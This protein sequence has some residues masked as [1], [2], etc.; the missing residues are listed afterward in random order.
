MLVPEPFAVVTVILLVTAPEG[1]VAVIWL[2]EF[3]VKAALVPRN[4][5][6]V[7]PV[8]DLPVIVTV[9]PAGPAG[10][11][12]PVTDGVTENVPTFTTPDP[13]VTVT[14]PF[15]AP[16]GTYAPIWLAEFTVNDAATP[17]NWTAVAPAKLRP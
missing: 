14:G 11:E 5:T 2:G 12:N 3:T 15:V 16:G 1:T 9:V 7:T 8:K 10:G 13:V 17:L 4:F 6:D